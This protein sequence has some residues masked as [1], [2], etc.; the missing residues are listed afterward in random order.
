MIKKRIKVFAPASVSNVG[1]G[2]D[3]LGF[4]IHKLGD[5]VSVKVNTINEIRITK[6]TGDKHKLPLNPDLNTCTVAIKSMLKELRSVQGFDIQIKKGVPGGS[7]LGSSAASAAAGVF[8]VN[9]IL[10]KPYKKNELL[11]FALKGEYIASRSVHADNV[12]PSLIGG[13][14]I[15]RSYNPLEIISIKAPKNLFCTV[16]LPDIEIN[17]SE[18][19][20]LIKKNISLST[21][22]NHF[23][24]I[25]ALT[26]ALY[27]KDFE[28]LGR[29]ITDLIAEPYRGVNIPGYYE[30]KKKA[31]DEGA[32]GCNISG[33]GPAIFSFFSSESEAWRVGRLMKKEL[34]KLK[35][36]RK[37]YVS[38]IN[39]HG[40][41]VING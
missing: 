20:K 27:T 18:S 6:I 37:L 15:I 7:G 11:P 13:F 1:C 9:E 36:A 34:T 32:F 39:I 29:T 3:T 16:L 28:L 5:E 25:A 23:G 31:L 12:A 33:S 21:A 41:R 26:S 2:F 30:I 38:K 14:L 17:T 24:N 22:R 19:R 4:A 40:A 10:G 35:I 8:A